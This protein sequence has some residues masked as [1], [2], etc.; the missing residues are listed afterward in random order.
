LAII[1][2][3]CS[4][5]I[6]ARSTTKSS[7]NKPLSHCSWCPMAFKKL[8]HCQRHE[9]THTND[10]PYTCHAEGCG[11]TFARQDTLNRH[12][13]L[14]TRNKEPHQNSDASPN[15]SVKRRRHQRTAS[16]NENVPR[17]TTIQS[18]HKEPTFSPTLADPSHGLPLRSAWTLPTLPSELPPVSRHYDHTHA[19]RFSFDHPISSNPYLT[20]PIY[21]SPQL[22]FPPI[23]F[24]AYRARRLSLSDHQFSTTCSNDFIAQ[25]LPSYFPTS[26]PTSL[27]LIGLEDSPIISA[28]SP[29]YSGTDT[30]NEDLYPTSSGTSVDVAC[31]PLVWSSGLGLQLGQGGFYQTN[32]QNDCLLGNETIPSYLSA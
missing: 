15:K 16:L 22:P 31:Q 13:R 14:H 32:H 8:E 30:S 2:L 21:S 4:R 10:R 11:K 9:R 5:S 27:G 23:S 12:S 1:L 20:S 28:P 26:F 7:A 3:P 24:E 18:F 17:Q 25:P 19:R 6:M 29:L